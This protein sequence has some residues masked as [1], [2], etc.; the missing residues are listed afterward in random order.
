M[1]E[2]SEKFRLKCFVSNACKILNEHDINIKE[3]RTNELIEIHEDTKENLGIGWNYIEKKIL[4][5]ISGLEWYF[6]QERCQSNKK[7]KLDTLSL[8]FYYRHLK[9][10]WIDF[11]DVNEGELYFCCDR[12]YW[13]I[14]LSDW[15]KL[16]LTKTDNPDYIVKFWKYDERVLSFQ[17]LDNR[18][19]E[20]Y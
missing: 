6:N 14:I 11:K 5:E 3:A 7:E 4:N 2:G 17:D 12:K 15:Q 16:R 18:A 13:D 9:I 1:K 8:L 19:F 10:Q 20:Y